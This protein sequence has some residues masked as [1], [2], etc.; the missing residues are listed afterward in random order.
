MLYQPIFSNRALSDSLYRALVNRFYN[1]L[2]LSTQ[3]LLDECTLGF[4]PS[5]EGVKTFFI[6]APSVAVAEEVIQ[7]LDSLVTQLG[8]MMAGV[9]Q[10]AIC[11]NPSTSEA[12]K[13]N[14]TAD[15]HREALPPCMA[16]KFFEIACED[17]D[18]DDLGTV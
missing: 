11:V 4:A 16:C 14:S 12:K 10:L 3:T 18:E 9:G 13:P 1:S 17:G 15:L 6:V 5:P 2:N 8:T 7:K